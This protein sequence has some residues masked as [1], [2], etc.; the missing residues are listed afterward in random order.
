MRKFLSLALLLVLSGCSSSTESAFSANDQMFAAMMVPHHE[1]AVEMSDIALSNSTNPA[2]LEIATEIKAAQQPEI[3][4][5]LSWGGDAMG[6][7]AGHT[8]DGMLSKTEINELKQATGVT[9]DRLFLIGMIKHHEGAI[10]MAKMVLDSKNPEAAALGKSITV[11][12]QQEIA[13][14]K[15]LLTSLAK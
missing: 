6:S 13:E 10:E 11:S 4:Q 3:D 14:M 9:F 1:Q 8:M 2:I 12:Q 15:K 5:M 7:H